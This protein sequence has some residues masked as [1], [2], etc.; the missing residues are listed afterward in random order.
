VFSILGTFLQSTGQ[1]D[2]SGIAASTSVA[3]NYLKM[4]PCTLRNSFVFIPSL[5]Q[6]P[7]LTTSAQT[8]QQNLICLEVHGLKYSDEVRQ[9]L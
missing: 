7:R 8:L 3:N 4:P 1:H 6:P 9:S 5:S 2:S